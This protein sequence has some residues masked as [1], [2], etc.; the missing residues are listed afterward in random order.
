MGGNNKQR[1]DA[2]AARAGEGMKKNPT[3]AGTHATHS[4]NALQA[5]NAHTLHAKIKKQKKITPQ[6]AM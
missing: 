4:Q 1:Q 2:A 5:L 3:R 6:N